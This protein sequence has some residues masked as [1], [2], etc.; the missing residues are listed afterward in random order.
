MRGYWGKWAV[1]GLL[2]LVTLGG[3]RKANDKGNRQADKAPPA[4]KIE[5]AV[6]SQSGKKA[7]AFRQLSEKEHGY[8]SWLIDF[9][10]KREKYLFRVDYNNIAS[11]SPDDRYLAT[12]N[13]SEKDP[14]KQF[15][16]FDLSTWTWKPIVVN[17]PVQS[18]VAR[19]SVWSPDGEK[20]AFD[21]LR[22]GPWTKS[23][24]Y[25]YDLSTGKCLPQGPG[26]MRLCGN[27]FWQDRILYSRMSGTGVEPKLPR[28][29]FSFLPSATG[30][31]AVREILPDKVVEYLSA[32][33]GKPYAAALCQEGMVK[34]GQYPR[35]YAIYLVNNADNPVVKK[36][37]SG[38]F[39]CSR[40]LILQWSTAGDELLTTQIEAGAA[41]NN[42]RL[43]IISAE[44]GKVTE[45][46]D[47]DGKSVFVLSARWVDNDRA[48]C[49][50]ASNAAKEIELWR[51][52][53]A[54][55][56]TTRLFPFQQ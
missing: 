53:R 35:K 43:V 8:S 30:R 48:I 6:F 10:E 33:P 14:W 17:S 40:G 15:G 44:T 29:F 11:W 12:W 42:L 34:S 37:A 9:P 22:E 23:T 38:K 32:A 18:R 28:R 21:G 2:A 26:E 4:G 13:I 56:G 20:L 45:L 55:K 31:K 27:P 3:C 16:M 36:L 49:Y 25:L 51:Y 46:S 7:V 1:V 41:R 52:D 50:S 47:R 24:I 54:S 39:A 5:G 19:F